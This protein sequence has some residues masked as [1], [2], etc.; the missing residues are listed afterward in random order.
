MLL[1]G[2]PC[3][4]GARLALAA[5]R[6]G[7]STIPSRHAVFESPVVGQLSRCASAAARARQRGTRAQLHRHHNRSTSFPPRDA[8]RRRLRLRNFSRP[9]PAPRS[10]SHG[11]YLKPERT[12]E[13]NKKTAEQP[14]PENKPA[15]APP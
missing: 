1:V 11:A 12:E 14:A 13:H 5:H 2:I 9:R 8:Q 4:L 6:D 15:T 10:R 3:A 7:G